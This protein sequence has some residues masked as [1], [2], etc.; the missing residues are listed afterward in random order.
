MGVITTGVSAARLAATLLAF[1]AASF[2]LGCGH[3]H[4]I[5]IQYQA[6]DKSGQSATATRPSEPTVSDLVQE[7]LR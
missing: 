3:F 6:G 2:L 1:A 4:L 5:T 7:A